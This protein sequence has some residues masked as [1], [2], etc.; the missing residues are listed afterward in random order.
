M[1]KSNADRIAKLERAITRQA[2][3]IS[4]L[5]Q[6]LTKLEVALAVMR[7]GQQAE[8]EAICALE[9]QVDKKQ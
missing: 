1:P 3:L 7:T 4:G 5:I 8:D 9:R 6:R 2:C